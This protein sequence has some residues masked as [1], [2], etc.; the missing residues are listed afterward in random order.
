MNRGPSTVKSVEPTEPGDP[1]HLP[2]RKV[3]AVAAIGAAVFAL[4]VL[5]ADRVLRR[6]SQSVAPAERARIPPEVGRSQIGM[7]NQRLFELEEEAPKKRQEQE[8][9]LNSYGWVDRDKQ[10]IHVPIE[11]AMEQMAAESRP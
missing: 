5:W 10:I 4:S 2:I 3:L 11:R 1:E 6:E 9:R 7:V 8:M